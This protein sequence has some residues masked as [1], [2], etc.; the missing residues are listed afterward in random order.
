[1]PLL[2]P[3]TSI[4]HE[5]YCSKFQALTATDLAIYYLLPYLLLL[6]TLLLTPYNPTTYSLLPYYLLLTTLPLTPK[7]EKMSLQASKEI[8]IRFSEVDSMNV[9][10]H[11][12]YALYFEDAREAFGAK[13]GLEYL[14]IADNGY[15]APLVELTFKYRQPIVYGMKCRIDIFYVPT[16]AAKIVFDYEIRRSEDNALMAT[17]HSVQA[18]MNKQYQLE[19]YRP[20]FYQEWQERWK[21]V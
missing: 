14:T 17:G 11:G 8:E 2:Q 21:V 16:E 13:Y 5:R 7:K 15:Y 6:T 4:I 9:V 18:F 10:W 12:S 19:W 3:K 20:P 1:M